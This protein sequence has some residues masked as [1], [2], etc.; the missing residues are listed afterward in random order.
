MSKPKPAES[1]PSITSAAEIAKKARRTLERFAEMSESIIATQATTDLATEAIRASK[2]ELQPGVDEEQAEKVIAAAVAHVTS[3]VHHRG[4]LRDLALQAQEYVA[5][6]KSICAALADPIEERRRARSAARAT[7][8]MIREYF[9]SRA[10][11]KSNDPDVE[12][13]HWLRAH[14]SCAFTI[15]SVADVE[16]YAGE[17]S[18]TRSVARDPSLE[19]RTHLAQTHGTTSKNVVRLGKKRAA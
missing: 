12:S 16:S 14:A 1:T 19:R 4:K 5:E 17:L 11:E 3:L 15:P 2:T 6:L 13:L 10:G 18:I 7:H 9:E 8:L